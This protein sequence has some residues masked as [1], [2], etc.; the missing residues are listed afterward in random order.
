MTRYEKRIFFDAIKRV[1]DATSPNRKAAVLVSDWMEDADPDFEWEPKRDHR[2]RR[3]TK[4]EWQLL[5]N[6]VERHCRTLSKSRPDQRDFSMR[7]L[8]E[9]VDLNDTE[10]AILRLALHSDDRR[11]IGGLCDLLVDDIRMDRHSAIALV[12]GH[13]ASIVR[14]ALGRDGRLFLTGL[15]ERPDWSRGRDLG[16]DVPR[17]IGR[18]IEGGCNPS[19]L[20]GFIR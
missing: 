3:V 1:L 2:A 18:L 9:M 12:V 15:I 16:L 4:E 8:G 11:G 10:V 17:Q 6:K 7:S 20:W 5:R 19:R 14:N 13:P